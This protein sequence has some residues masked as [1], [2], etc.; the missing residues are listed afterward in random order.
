MY[1]PRFDGAVL[2]ALLSIC[3]EK[4]GEGNSSELSIKRCTKASVTLGMH[5]QLEYHLDFLSKAESFKH[6]YKQPSHSIRGHFNK[7]LHINV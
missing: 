6:A 5:A 1:S 7:E 2:F 3:Q 4:F